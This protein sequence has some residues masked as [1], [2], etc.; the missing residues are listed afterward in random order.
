[1]KHCWRREKTKKKPR[2]RSWKWMKFKNLPFNKT[3]TKQL[4]QAFENLNQ[5]FF[6]LFP[7]QSCFQGFHCFEAYF[8]ESQ[9][10]MS[11]IFRNFKCLAC[12]K[13]TSSFGESLKSQITT[14]SRLCI[15]MTSQWRRSIEKQWIEKLAFKV[16]IWNHFVYRKPHI[17]RL[18]VQILSSLE[19]PAIWG[20]VD[21]Q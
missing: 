19:K 10:K 13:V 8:V 15:R 7:F 2:T 4:T 14:F 17:L 5:E 9:F 1:M 11:S 21:V 3:E 6:S 16:L 18:Q 12:L 20:Y